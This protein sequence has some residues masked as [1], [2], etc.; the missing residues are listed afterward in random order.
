MAEA[1]GS[2]EG[3]RE[4]LLSG[5][6]ELGLKI[7]EPQIAAHGRHLE[8]I[9]AH[10]ARAGLTTITDPVEI[11]VKHF[12]D[13]LSG[14]LAREI[15]AGEWVAEV[16]SGGGFPGVVLAAA[17]PDAS[18]ALIES[19]RKRAAFLSELIEALGLG[20][21]RVVVGR[22][23]EVGRQ[24]EHRER[25][26]LVVS[27]AVAPLPV[28]LEYCLPL[29]RVGG[30]ALAYKGPEAEAEMAQSAVALETL[31]GRVAQVRRLSLPQGMGDRVLVVISKVAP[32]PPAYPRRPGVAKRRPLGVRGGR[33]RAEKSGRARSRGG[34]DAS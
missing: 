15:A 2:S 29:A 4:A 17:R 34:R 11:A 23:E 12:L 33:A 28:L 16:G 3:W 6:A 1:A 13:S 25:Y 10:N 24:A 14:L 32:T 8:L 5:A 7:P 20:Q 22:A 9:L 26:D 19:N 18:Y 21:A 30:E 27:R 31:G